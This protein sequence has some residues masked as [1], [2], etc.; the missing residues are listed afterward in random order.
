MMRA[1]ASEQEW[2]P[3]Q[4]SIRGAVRIFMMCSFKSRTINADKNMNY[5]EQLN[6]G[7]R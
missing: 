7:S 4:R 2:H 3:M 1:Q 6:A 5:D